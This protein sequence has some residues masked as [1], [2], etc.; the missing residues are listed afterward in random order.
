MS[1]TRKVV[2]VGAGPVGCLAAMAFARRS[3]DVELYEVRP[4][5]RLP[6]SR[7]ASRQRSINL[8]ISPRGIVAIQ[9]VNPAAAQKFLDNAIPM[10]G[11]M[12]HSLDGS[13]KSQKY[14]RYGQ[15]THLGQCINSIDRFLLNESLLAEAAAMPNIWMF[16]RHKV[17]AIDFD[18]RTMSVCDQDTNTNLTVHFDLC[19]GADGSYSVVRR[20]LMRF[21]RMD[22][23]QDYL[24][25]EY[26]ELR[27]PAGKDEKGDPV[28]LLDPDHL[29]IWPRLSYM[30][31]ALPN[32]DRTFTCTLF[33]PAS[34][35]DTLNS[36]DVFLNWFRTQFPDA[37]RRIGEDNLLKDFINNPRSALMCANPYHYKDRA[38]ILGDAAHSMVPFYGQGLNCGLEDVRVLDALL[39]S[40]K[41]DGASTLKEPGNTDDKLAAALDCYSVNR[42]DDLVAICDMALNNYVEMR[43]DV[44][45]PMFLFK[46]CV[47]NALYALTTNRSVSLETLVPILSKVPFPI[48]PVRGWLPLYTMVTFRPDISYATVRRR[49]LQQARMVANSTWLAT[50][51]VA[52]AGIYGALW[53]LRSKQR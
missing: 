22:Y 10:Q 47:D 7:E 45:S 17:Q 6:A 14:D 24:K 23:A 13:T 4:D 40:E 50:S 35:L 51:V 42:H 28:F 26:I 32:K 30:L 2:V 27:M 48:E 37:L 8:A 43:H 33:A 29:H 1:S 41:V 19:I 21:V 20:Q 46:K 12:I 3:W 39:E 53:F 25:D 34:L 36:P 18:S 52:A 16:F 38:I 31:I 11:R 44:I 49:A 5:L 9:A 15:A